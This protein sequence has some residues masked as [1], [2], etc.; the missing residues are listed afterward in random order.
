MLRREQ[1]IRNI[2]LFTL[3][4]LVFIGV[5]YAVI[6]S[7]LQMN[8]SMTLNKITWD[9]HF[10]NFEELYDNTVTGT[11]TL[12]NNNTTLT[13]NVNL[14]KPGD[15]FEFTIDVVN[16]GNIDAMLSSIGNNGLTSAQQ[17]VMDYNV[18]Y[19]DGTTPTV[20]DSLKVGEV[21]T[22]VVSVKT[23]VDITNSQLAGTDTNLT[24]TFN[25][26]YSQDDETSTIR[27][28]SLYSKIVDGAELDNKSSLNVSL[29]TG[30]NFDNPSSTSNGRG[31][32]LRYNSINNEN[33][34]YYY[35]GAVNNNNVKFGG[36]CWLI[37]RTTDVGGIKIV[38]NGVPDENGK[39]TKPADETHDYRMIAYSKFVNSS[40]SVSYVG[41][42]YG[43][44]KNPQSSTY[45]NT[46]YYGK[47][48]SYNNGEYTLTNTTSTLDSTHHFTCLTNAS[49]CNTLYFVY[50]LDENTMY[51]LELKNGES[52]DDVFN[53][54][55]ANRYD[56]LAK[57]VIDSWYKN[58]LIN[59]R[60]YL[61]DEEWCGS[62][63]W[64]TDSNS[65]GGTT[66]GELTS[67]IGYSRNMYSR[68]TGTPQL[69]CPLKRD[70]Y[71]V[72]ETTTGNGKLSYP[73]ALLTTDE[74]IIAGLSGIPTGSYSND[75]YLFTGFNADTN[76]NWYTMSPAAFNKDHSD[77]IV[78]GYNS[79]IYGSQVSHSYGIRPAIS[80]KKGTKIAGGDGTQNNPYVIS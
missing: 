1:K 71:T 68:T 47:N 75:T 23:K 19:L 77:V 10:E 46:Y 17:E 56:S 41:Y 11:K 44:D 54:A 40:S 32:Y 8:G 35:R 25:P 49:N 29:S 34:I 18:T 43:N 26:T 79:R 57:Q 72:H 50:Y 7:N 65:L 5:G 59:Q 13:Y 64:A 39:C 52:L 55:Y 51:Y 45:S 9:V 16:N 66:T 3:F 28:T 38:Y 4:S 37:V 67:N 58:N 30:I 14:N 22:F 76:D 80:L 15:V 42:M 60:K 73:I 33:N 31:K 12:T 61:V 6:S 53:D 20:K 21:E 69:S 2:I 63:Q 74:L 70:N 27:N 36:Y 48:Y 62:R 78:Y 24:L